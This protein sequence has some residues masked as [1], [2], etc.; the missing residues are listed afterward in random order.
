MDTYTW[1]NGFFPDSQLLQILSV[2][3]FIENVRPNIINAWKDVE[4]IFKIE[5]QQSTDS[6][7]YKLFYFL[8]FIFNFLLRSK[9]I[10]KVVF[11]KFNKLSL[12]ARIKT[13]IN[14]INK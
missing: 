2:A 3:Q 13:K 14:R 1:W 8:F 4:E 12:N 9:M 10:S 6:N 7:L 5:I 11:H